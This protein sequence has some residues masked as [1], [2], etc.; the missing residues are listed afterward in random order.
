MNKAELIKYVAEKSGISLLKARA[1]VNAFCDTIVKSIAE[2][3]SVLL[4]R[5]GKWTTK[6]TPSRR[7]YNVSTQ[8]IETFPSKRRV[9]FTPSKALLNR[10]LPEAAES[11][12]IDI[13]PN[14]ILTPLPEPVDRKVAKMGNGKSADS[15][16]PKSITVS[17][18]GIKIDSGSPNFGQRVKRPQTVETGELVYCGITSYYETEASDT[19]NY[20]YPALL[21]PF[22]DTPILDYRTNRYATG[23]VMEPVLAEALNEFS[24]IEPNI[25]ILQNISVPVNNRTYGY[26]P[27]IAIIWR[28]KNIFIDVEIDEP[29]DIISRNPTHYKGCGDGLRNAYFLDNGWSVIRVAEKQIVDDYAKVVEYIKLCLYQL[30]EDVRFKAERNIDSFER[31]SYSESQKWAEEG[32]RE[33]Y[34]GITRV[35]SSVVSTGAADIA[36][37]SGMSIQE[38]SQ[39]IFVKPAED[40][41]IDRYKNIRDQIDEECRRGKYIVFSIK[42]KC[43]EYAALSKNISFKQKD[44]SYGVELF[45]VIEENVIYLRFQEIASFRSLNSITKFEGTANDDWDK[46]IYNAIL[47]SNPIE[48]EYDTAG[49]GNP[50]KR[51]ILFITFWYRFFDENDNRKKYTTIQLLEAAASLKYETLAESERVGYFS[52]FCNYRQDLRTFNIHRIKGGRVFECRKNLHK[53]SVTDIWKILEK[54]YADLTVNMYNELNEKEQKYLFHLGNYANALVMQ[55]KLEEATSVY[56]SVPSD[57]L[58]PQSTTTWKEA[59]LN[60]FDFFITK[61]T[62][63]AEFEQVRSIMMSNGW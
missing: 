45:D 48:I 49:Q 22:V 25:Q 50:I 20:S 56:M 47:N 11:V 58:M 54:G 29:Y 6:I 10:K 32:L 63:T 39:P 27:D 28:E 26:K 34:L 2:G 61:G 40:I 19:E 51:T 59:C 43:Y 57:V 42:H 35:E 24:L 7:A 55:G 52:G 1:V 62:N 38:V 3:D 15:Q 12:K 4:L 13:T 23:G 33:S 53:L 36:E 21:I 17:R 5:F 46:I 18:T 8:R 60:D 31:W 14:S 41:I 37:Y 16:T 30:S 9:V 44:N